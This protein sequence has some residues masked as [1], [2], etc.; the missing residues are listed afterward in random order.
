MSVIPTQHLNFLGGLLPFYETEE[1]FF[2]H[3]NYHPRLPLNRQTPH[4]LRWQ[5]LT[6][7]VPA[8][9]LSGKLAVVGHTHDRAGEIFA[10]PHLVCLDTF[11]YGGGWLTA[12]EFPSRRIWQAD[13][14][15]RLRANVP[16]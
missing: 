14:T 12:M 1:V 3:A 15:G 10:V 16:K 2:V 6:E 8:P 9:H 5:K 4:A 13:M 7:L 11:C